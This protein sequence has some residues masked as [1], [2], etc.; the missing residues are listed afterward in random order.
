MLK[1]GY[2][3]KRSKSSYSVVISIPGTTKR[4]WYTIKG[5]LKEA[6]RFLTEKLREL[7]T[8][9]LIDNKN[10]TFEQFLN[11]WYSERCLSKL[12]PTTYESYR[13]NLDKYII[14]EL[15]YIKLEDLLPLH[16]QT[17]YRKCSNKGLSNTSVIYIHRIIHCALKQAMKWQLLIRNVADCV[18]LPKKERYEA[19]VLDSLDILKLITSIKD[20]QI[21]I[22]IMIAISTGMRRGE[23]LGLTWDNVDLINGTI[24]IV[25]ALYPTK[26]GLTILPPKSQK[27]RRII[28]ISPTLI[29]ILKEY[30]LE[31]Q[32]KII[33]IENI[34]K[35]NFVVC[36]EDSSP[37]NPTKLNHSFKDILKA[38]RLPEIRFHDLRHTH[39]SLLLSQG[40]QP[41]VVSDRLGHSTIAITMDLYSHTYEAVDKEVARNF[42]TFLRSS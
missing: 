7:D 25:Q 31:Q 36:N 2:I 4:K 14:K 35:Q 40:V 42:D 15:G 41:K 30:K 1:R 21:Y 8:G 22:P 12:S 20:T 3:T 26:S 13:R 9:M 16:L 19:K 6:R 28:S 24:K 27:S 18:E 34:Y 39:A 29:K 5:D 32:K 37:Y 23:I 11:Y 33:N 10:M 38:H 17:F